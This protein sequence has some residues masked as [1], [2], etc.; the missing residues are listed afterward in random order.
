[1]DGGFGRAW[2]ALLHAREMD[3]R[4]ARDAFCQHIRDS[5]PRRG[6]SPRDL[7]VVFLGV[8]GAGW[9]SFF[10]PEFCGSS[11][12]PTDAFDRRGIGPIRLSAK[13][14]QRMI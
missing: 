1:V 4:D 14:S 5:H 8:V 6:L 7:G 12:V 2:R 3:L 13:R 11:A 10:P 9:H